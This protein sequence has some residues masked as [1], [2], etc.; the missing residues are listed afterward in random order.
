MSPLGGL[1]IVRGRGYRADQ[2]DAYL[3][4][5][6]A[7]RE[8]AWAEVAR[9]REQIARLEAE[10]VHLAQRIA[11]LGPQTYDELTD[12]ARRILTL[13]QEESEMLRMEARADG[14][15]TYAVAQAE[16]DRLA[17]SVR[18]EAKAVRERAEVRA[19]QDLLRAERQAEDLRTE[20]REDAA[21]WRAQAEAALT[22]TARRA[23]ALLADREA[24]QVERWD[25]AERDIAAR[26]AELEGRHTELEAYSDARLTEARRA[27][28]QA[29]E[30]ARHGQEDAE[31]RAAEMLSQARVQ[32]E[33]IGRETERLLREH[34]AQQD[35]MRAHMSHVRAS[36]AA[37][38]GRAPA[39]Q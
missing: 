28:A 14:A 9:L 27:F 1:A 37:L 36:L 2:V 25:T 3:S 12:R 30:E 5:L 20:A 15:G 22:E 19:R 13:A 29:E 35:E 38:T 39:E 16:A 32:E 21:Q 31:A 24:E 8:D 10:S 34:G 23:D 33:R 7:G 18:E 4:R 6:N 26:G 11:N 17:E